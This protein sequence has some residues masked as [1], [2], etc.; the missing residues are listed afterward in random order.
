MGTHSFKFGGDVR[1]QRFDQTLY[2]NV[3]GEYFVDG[4]SANTTAGDTVFS[5]YLLGSPVPT[6]RA[7]RKY[8]N[9]RS[10][11]L[12]LF[13][14][15]SW[16]IKQNM[17]LNYGLRWELNTP[18][19]DIGQH[20]QTFRPGQNSAIYPCQLNAQSVASFQGSGHRE[21]RLH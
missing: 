21:S 15:D 19:A 10:T 2:F 16:K 17:T 20:V 7:P 1:R 12:Y 11:S 18:I 8:E 13:A 14:Q 5:D 4:S 6:V 9:V 3:N